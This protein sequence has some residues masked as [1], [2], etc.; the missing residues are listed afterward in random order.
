[1]SDPHAAHS[2]AT[3]IAPAVRLPRG[4][5]AAT[6]PPVSPYRRDRHQ[7]PARESSDRSRPVEHE[8]LNMHIVGIGKRTARAN[9]RQPQARCLIDGTS[10]TGR[11][12]D[13]DTKIGSRTADTDER[14]GTETDHHK[15]QTGHSENHRQ[16]SCSPHANSRHVA[17]KH[18][19]P[20]S[21]TCAITDRAAVISCV[22]P[23]SSIGK[24]PQFSS[25][26]DWVGAAMRSRNRW[27]GGGGVH[28]SAAG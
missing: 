16:P 7:S 22:S 28:R 11:V 12:L 10:V 5:R 21:A 15:H 2:R 27:L 4:A 9:H 8:V 18:S 20:C 26:K 25:R 19:Q 13:T 14:Q 23:G 3:P 6:R 1:M 24:C 17:A